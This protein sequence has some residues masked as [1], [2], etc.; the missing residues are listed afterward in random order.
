MMRDRGAPEARG[1]R[2]QTRL[3]LAE[4]T[5]PKAALLL[6]MALSLS[7]TISGDA[8]GS[9]LGDAGLRSLQRASSEVRPSFALQDLAGVR[10]E[11]AQQT[12]RI[13]LVHFF[14]TWCETC[15]AELSSLAQLLDRPGAKAAFVLAVNVGEVPARVR[16]FLDASPV[17]FPVLLDTDRAVTK[18]WG[19]SI[20]P[21]TFVLD[22]AGAVRLFVEGDIDWARADVQTALGQLGSAD[23]RMTKTNAGKE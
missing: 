4:G 10:H 5:V 12:G 20:L 15:R 3:R 18:A 6:L 17:S 8:R 19:V 9:G 23:S 11:L 7:P 2:R 22:R 16:R 21:T 13:V 1:T 14:A